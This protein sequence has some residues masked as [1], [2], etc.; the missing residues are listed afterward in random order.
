M[1]SRKK[2]LPKSI[3]K[4]LRQEK[5]RLRKE[6]DD[7]VKLEKAFADLISHYYNNKTSQNHQSDVVRKK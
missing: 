6:L 4:H 5:A 3:R 7:Q 1:S 2:R